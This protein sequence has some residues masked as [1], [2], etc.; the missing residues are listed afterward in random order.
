MKIDI[1]QIAHSLKDR[2]PF[3]WRMV[4]KVN[5]WLFVARYGRIIRRSG[6]SDEIVADGLEYRPLLESDADSLVRF[7]DSQPEEA[8][9]FF[10]P[11]DFDKET[12]LRLIRNRS[13]LAYGVFE[14][15]EVVGYYFLRSFFMGK[16]YL[17][18]MVD[19]NHRGQGIGKQICKLSMD[20]ATALGLHMYETISKD[21]L[22]SLYSTQKVL[23][24]KI[25]K[26]L[27]DNYLYIEDFPKGTLKLD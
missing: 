25:L 3:I 22:S 13:Y 9:V 11:H 24:V 14:K 17:G 10:K 4:E 18:K 5:E 26:E 8:F 27:P 20:V 15:G 23:D 1:Y 6:V 7:F 16:S 21:N 2:L 12:V 19:I